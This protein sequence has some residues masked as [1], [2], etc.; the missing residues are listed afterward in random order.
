MISRF[1]AKVTVVLGFR[2]R[3]LPPKGESYRAGFVGE[4]Q[5]FDFGHGKFGMSELS[6]KELYKQILF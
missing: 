1:L 2:E 4:D 6:G 5:K 3:E